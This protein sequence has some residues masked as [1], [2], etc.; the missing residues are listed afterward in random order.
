M[1]AVILAGGLGTRLSEETQVKPKP[2]IEIGGMPIL[3]HIMKIYSHYGYNEFIICLGYKGSYIREWFNNYYLHH[4]DMTMD[5][6][7][8]NITFHKNR[9]EPWK[10][11]LVDTGDGTM[12]GG[13]L[14]RV[15]EHIG[16]KA[17]MMTYGDGVC[18][19]RIDKLVEYHKSHTADVTMTT[20]I[21]EGRFGTVVTNK[22][23][24]ITA[25]SEKTDN[26]NRVNGGFFVFEP[27]LFEYIKDDTTI[28]EREPLETFAREGNINAYT[29]DGFWM[30]MDKL[31]DKIKLDELWRQ[32]K[33]PWKFW[34]NK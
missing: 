7:K 13:R 33:A 27:N 30:P 19:I 4:S 3:W 28:L 12:T 9:S 5:L 17:F 16:N 26:K 20:V 15:R 25:F 34:K 11:T 22:K 2:M 31:S 18:D 29:H 14:K 32:G 21:P 24:G 8:N 23:N 6:K 10:V 1:K